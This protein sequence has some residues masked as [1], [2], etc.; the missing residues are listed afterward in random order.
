MRFKIDENMPTEVAEILIGA[1]RDAVTVLD[2][3]KRMPTAIL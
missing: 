3:H 1:G 2:Q